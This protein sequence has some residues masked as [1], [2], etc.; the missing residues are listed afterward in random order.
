MFINPSELTSAH[1]QTDVLVVGSGAAGI[2]VVEQLR[3]TGLD[4]LLVESGGMEPDADVQGL[5]QARSVG[6]MIRPEEGR[7]RCFG[8]TTSAWTGRCAPFDTLDFEKRDWVPGSGW[9]V[10]ADE[11]DAYYRRAASLLGLGDDWGTDPPAYAS[12]DDVGNW[13]E[14][15]QAFY[16]RFHSIA[17]GS[18]LHFGK[19]VQAQYARSENPRV[20]LNANL[21]GLTAASGGKSISEARIRL[22]GNAEV[23][24]GFRT[25]ILCCGAIENTRLLLNFAEDLPDAFGPVAPSIGRWFMQHPRAPTAQIHADARQADTL[26]KNFNLHRRNGF[27][28]ERGFALSS[29]AQRKMK[30]L[31]A[32]AVLRYADRW[33]DSLMRSRLLP[34]RRAPEA[35][36]RYAA[37]WEPRHYNPEI[38]LHVDVEQVPDRESAITLERERDVLGMRRARIDWKINDADRRTAAALTTFAGAWIEAN[39]LGRV[40]YIAGLE[41]TGGLTDDLMLESYH[42][43]G[44]TRISHSPATGVVDQNLRVH[45]L[46]NLFVCGGSVMP[47]GGHANPTFTIVA[48]AMKLADHLKLTMG[49]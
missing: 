44:S 6:A 38:V 11:M 25:M 10:T 47:T 34:L 22:P 36:L 29:S 42:H 9:P 7:F 21:I 1:L 20:L 18:F 37:G 43:L 33:P 39:N 14:E 45:G 16:W 30:L 4:V 26:Q 46:S 32:S 5:F 28:Y 12:A 17:R 15:I 31:N 19:M 3:D 23:A 40:E 35:L 2:T 13:P 49:V 8:G 48:L 24:I 27:H 41:E